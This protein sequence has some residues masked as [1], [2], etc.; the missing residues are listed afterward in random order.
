MKQCNI[1]IKA[2]NKNIIIATFTLCS[3]FSSAQVIIG[4]A[5]GTAAS[6]D[7]ASVLLEFAN[8]NNKGIVVPTVRT[9]PSGT[10]LVQGTIILDSSV[11]DTSNNP[12]TNKARVKFY[13]AKNTSVDGGWVDLSGQDGDVTT[14][15]ANQPATSATVTDTGKTIIGAT[16]SSAEGVLVLESS[17]KA[18]VLPVV[19]DYAN[20]KNPAPGMM[21][22]LKP[23]TGSAHYRL[24][25]FNGSKWSF[26]KP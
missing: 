26:W 25:V 10:G 19:T 8:T 17:T 6:T 16:S 22:F 9:K 24:I 18:M 7:K 2:M 20:I 5:T 4:D 21:A 3:A 13:N 14:F 11:L 1:K 12:T 15:L 23:A